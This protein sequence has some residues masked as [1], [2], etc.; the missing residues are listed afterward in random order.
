MLVLILHYETLNIWKYQICYEIILKC[1]FIQ[2][3][4]V[5]SDLE[6]KQN[7]K[8]DI[9]VDNQNVKICNWLYK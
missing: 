2:E 6:L 4:I 8:F 3:R 7:A 5:F 1:C 9:G